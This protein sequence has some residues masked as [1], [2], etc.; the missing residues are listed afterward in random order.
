MKGGGGKVITY[1]TLTS[2]IL[3]LCGYAARA[4]SVATEVPGWAGACGCHASVPSHI[5]CICMRC[6]SCMRIHH[7]IRTLSFGGDIMVPPGGITG[8]AI[9]ALGCM[10]APLFVKL[11]TVVFFGVPVASESG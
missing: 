1:Y 8:F 5:G 10:G 4:H 9:A 6:E 2:V 7:T 11:I 3:L